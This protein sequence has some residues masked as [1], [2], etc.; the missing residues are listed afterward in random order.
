[1]GIYD[2]LINNARSFDANGGSPG[3]DR[4][5]SQELLALKAFQGSNL[6]YPADAIQ[7]PAS[8]ALSAFAVSVTAG[9]YKITVVLADGVSFQTAAINHNGN[10]AAIQSAIN[11]AA[12]LAVVGYTNGDIVVAGGP[13]HSTPGSLTFSGDS[14]S[15][16]FAPVVTVQS[17]TTVGAVTQTTPGGT[18]VDEVQSIAAF[19]TPVTGGT[20]TLTINLAG[21][22]A[23]TTANIAYTANA[24]TIETAIDVAATLASVP[25]WVNGNISVSGGPLTTT[26]AVLTFDGDLVD[27]INHP[28]A[29]I[30]GTNLTANFNSTILTTAADGNPALAILV[31]SGVIALNGDD[32]V[33]GAQLRGPN[34][35]SGS[36]IQALA[37]EAATH[38]DDT[39]YE[40]RILA[41]AGSHLS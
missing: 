3:T 34:Y 22:L 16:Y 12:T 18:G 8:V 17:F 28:N 35:P 27:E 31:A 40:A 38:S 33:A 29:S 32:F 15:S 25:S 5:F 6:G 41:A 1:M 14:V 26:P 13:L 36:L 9:T 2:D 24:A 20:Y 11:A 21:P 4:A 10:T 37:R 23:F 39:T 19:L 7:E 30:S